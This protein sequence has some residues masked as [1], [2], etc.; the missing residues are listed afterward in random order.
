MDHQHKGA[1]VENVNSHVPYDVERSF[2]L[3]RVS[4]ADTDEA[5]F[6]GLRPGLV[7]RGMSCSVGEVSVNV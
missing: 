6:G 5:R 7:L 3:G 4:A 2:M 1:Y